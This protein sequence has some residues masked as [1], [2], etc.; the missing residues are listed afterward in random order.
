MEARVDLIILG[1]GPAG[2]SLLPGDAAAVLFSAP[3]LILRTARHPA[4][5][6]LWARGVPFTS[7][8][9]VYDRTPSFAELYPRLSEAVL[10]EAGTSGAAPV[11][12]AVPGHPLMGEESVK[13]LLRSAVDRGLTTRVIPAPGFVD[14]VATAL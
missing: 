11:V 1:L 13:L 12:Y 2:L 9:Q 5:E 4:A 10:E 3:R 6:E 8:D 14:V 7:L